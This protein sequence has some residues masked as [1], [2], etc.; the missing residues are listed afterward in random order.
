M[1]EVN[2]PELVKWIGYI[3]VI[4]GVVIGAWRLVK[5]GLDFIKKLN[6]TLDSLVNETNEQALSILRLTVYNEQLPLSERIIAGKKYIKKGGNGDV[7]HY[8]EDHLLPFDK[9]GAV[10]GETEEKA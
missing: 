10:H 1:I 2:V 3:S 8:V 7:K 6:T 9:V 5:K 4:G